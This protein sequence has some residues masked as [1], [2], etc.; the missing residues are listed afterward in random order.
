MPQIADDNA[1]FADKAREGK[2]PKIGWEWMLVV[3]V[4]FGAFASAVVRR[5]NAR[6]GPEL[7]VSRFGPSVT[8]RFLAA[9][10]AGVVMMFG[11]RLTVGNHEPDFG[12]EG[13]KTLVEARFPVVAA[14]L[15]VN[16]GGR[17]F[18]K[19]YVVRDRRRER[20]HL[21]AGLPKTPWTT[22]SRTSKGW[23]SRHP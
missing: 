15:V 17:L 16:P 22:S 18:S 8:V 7:W 1:Y 20:R 13:M 3:G 5:Y 2:P 19:A 23:S 10:L 4:F 21:G 6:E 11:A 14:N 9:L 12:R